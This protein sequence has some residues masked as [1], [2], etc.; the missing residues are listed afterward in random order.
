MSSAVNQA[1]EG[2]PPAVLLC[3][4]PSGI[5]VEPGDVLLGDADAAKFV[6]L[7]VR[8][9][10]RHR[11]TGTGPAVIRLGVRRLAYRLVDLRA[12]IDAQRIGG[13]DA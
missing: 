13:T 2:Q 9:L 10:Q 1:T 12:W 8:T 4:L 6:G 11:Q 5:G 3:H 7:G